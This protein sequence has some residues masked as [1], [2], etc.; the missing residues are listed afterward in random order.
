MLKDDDAVV[1][2]VHHNSAERNG[3]RL[4]VDC[5]IVFQFKSGLVIDARE[6]YYDLHAWD[7]FW[8]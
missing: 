8:A 7:A 2:G 6:H 1:V 3:K 4:E 5:C